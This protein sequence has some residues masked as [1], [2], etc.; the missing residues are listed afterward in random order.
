[1][2]VSLWFEMSDERSARR[3]LYVLSMGRRS[4]GG[5]LVRPGLVN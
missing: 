5:M 3:D 2:T 4:E 1:M